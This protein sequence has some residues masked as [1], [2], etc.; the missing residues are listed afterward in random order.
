MTTRGSTRAGV[1]R[2]RAGALG[3][4]ALLVGLLVPASA[5]ASPATYQRFVDAQGIVHVTNV[6]RASEDPWKPAPAVPGSGGERLARDVAAPA[7]T[8]DERVEPRSGAG[9][10]ADVV[11][12]IHRYDVFIAGAAQRYQ[13]PEALIR[14]V[15]H[16][17]SRYN[18]DAVSH[19][20][21]M[22][23]MQLM[24]ATARYLGVAQ[25][26]DPMQN[27]YGGS[28]YLRLLANNFNG[29]MVLVLAGY[30]SGAGAVKKYGGV[31]PH[32]GVR[33]YVK[34]VL[35][36]YYA[37]EA[38]ARRVGLGAEQQPTRQIM[39]SAVTPDRAPE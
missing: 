1:R 29:D 34:A 20:G 17:E 10:L 2:G 6:E 11:G 4:G 35:R 3:I 30:F 5:G 31:P 39:P 24:P 18:P 25:P 32:P 19:V 27:I 15:I 16:T 36:R 12:D 23:L 21:A 14:A 28:K 26:F 7:G 8:S 22:G 13:L 33:R 38:H 37:Y 9:P